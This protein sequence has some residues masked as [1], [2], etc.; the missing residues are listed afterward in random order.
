MTRNASAWTLPPWP[1]AVDLSVILGTHNRL[2]PL[3]A[4]LTGIRAAVGTLSYEIVVCDG[5]STD[6]SREWLASQKDVVLFGDWQLTGA[7]AAFNQGF[8]LS[9]GQYIAALN[10]DCMPDP[11]VLAAGVKRLQEDPKIGQVAFELWDKKRNWVVNKIHDLHWANY[12]I[13]SAKLARKIASVC[14]G[15]WAPCYATAGAD[16]L[17][18]WVA[19]VTESVSLHT[20]LQTYPYMTHYGFA[21]Q[22][23]QRRKRFAFTTVGLAKNVT[24][25]RAPTFPRH[26]RDSTRLFDAT[27]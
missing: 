2:E 10:D 15:L 23:V 20:A 17:S 14:G 24:G 4:C 1:G 5:G 25:V 16:E 6:G 11:G 26:L 21:I 12:G 7:V 18:L 22:L 27:T 9:R 13:L 19:T 8:A 3:Q